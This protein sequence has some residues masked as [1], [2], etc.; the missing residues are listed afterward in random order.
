MQPMAAA[1]T[2]DVP[3]P[4]AP[5]ANAADQLSSPDANAITTITFGI[6]AS[7]LALLSVY[8]GYLQLRAWR[9]SRRSSR[10]S[11]MLPSYNEPRPIPL[12]RF[13]SSPLAFGYFQ[14]VHVNI[15]P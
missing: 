9:Q 10:R 13:E 2:R 15:H 8:F 12:Q 4:D 11:P 5:S 3:V 7:V 1:L 14:P 6:V